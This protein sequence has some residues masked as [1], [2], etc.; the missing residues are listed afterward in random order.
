[1][2]KKAFIGLVCLLLL[3]SF[4][5]FR[6]GAEATV[7][8][9]SG[10]G[11]RETARILRQEGIIASP[12]TFRLLAK[13]TL[14]DRQ[15]K[16]GTFR[17]RRHMSSVEVLWR[18][19]H[20]RPDFIKVVIPEGF[21][22]TQIADRLG[23]SGVTAAEGFEAFT[24][25]NRLEGYLFPTTY[26]LS[27]SMEPEAVARLMHA[28]FERM[29]E[30]LYRRGAQNTRLTLEQVVTLASIVEREAVHPQEKPMIAAVYLNRLRKRMRLEADPTVQYALSLLPGGTGHW[31]RGLS[32]KD[33]Q[34]DSP[35]NTY[36]QFGLPPGP[37]CSP[38]TASVEA[39]MEP[40]PTDALYFVSDAN[41]GHT[42]SASYDEHLKAVHQLRRELRRRRTAVPSR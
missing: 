35:Y 10:A 33:L 36:L 29:A 21:N 37:I 1:M 12:R 22:A 24:R 26:F 40:S 2:L 42:F 39:V 3:L 14:L 34:I 11:A 4:W 27:A 6:V 30:P 20:G 23:A 8:L 18:L 5:L 13:L 16:P 15:L 41:G 25:A 38:S 9:P 19:T 7:T 28:E 32:K 31:K 17:L